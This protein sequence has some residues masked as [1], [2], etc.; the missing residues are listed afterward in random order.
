[1]PKVKP[2]LPSPETMN[3]GS[4]GQRWLSYYSDAKNKEF[5]M[6]F[7]LAKEKLKSVREKREFLRRQ[8]DALRDRINRIQ[9]LKADAAL[10][11][12]NLV[13]KRKQFQTR[14]QNDL[15]AQRAGMEERRARSI[16]DQQEAR[17]RA[18]YRAQASAMRSAGKGRIPEDI[19]SGL[20][21]AY[22]NSQGQII[23]SVELEVTEDG[24]ISTN[25]GEAIV[26]DNEERNSRTQSRPVGE[27]NTV[28]DAR[29]VEGAVENITNKLLTLSPGTSPEDAR[30]LAKSQVR[31]ELS[32]LGGLGEKYLQNY[33][34]IKE[35][36]RP[37]APGGVPE[38]I[39][40]GLGYGLPQD[41]RG[42]DPGPLESPDLSFLNR[43]EASLRDALKEAERR[44]QTYEEPDLLDLARQQQWEKFD[45]MEGGAEYPFQAPVKELDTSS[46]F[47][48]RI[49]PDV[50]P[51][52]IPSPAA[53]QRQTQESP[54]QQGIVQKSEALPLPPPED[55]G[56]LSVDEK[57]F[58]DLAKE[59]L[60]VPQMPQPQETDWLGRTSDLGSSGQI[61][62][63]PQFKPQRDAPV[64]PQTLEGTYG[65]PGEI[66]KLPSPTQSVGRAG[67]VETVPGVYPQLPQADVAGQIDEDFFRQRLLPLQGD[68]DLQLN[69]PE[70]PESRLGREMEPDV[71]EEDPFEKEKEERG[72]G[73]S[74]P[75][76][77]SV[78]NLDEESLDVIV[79]DYY[80]DGKEPESKKAI[81]VA[82][83]LWESWVDS[84]ITDPDDV[85]RKASEQIKKSE[86]YTN[87]LS[88]EEK[89]D[90]LLWLIRK[91]DEEE[92]TR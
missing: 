86:A 64:V 27:M 54:L 61:V 69:L 31:K 3:P 26:R 7:E 5:K 29:M 85:A 40:G 41:I 84:G 82:Q 70:A 62:N 14:E 49:T 21:E 59:R 38:P 12:A 53:V 25:L 91:A 57:T 56:G 30:A 77:A 45:R 37:A 36:T 87:Y 9:Q 1:M 67:V 32:D 28:A 20:E 33:E 78:L 55:L 11:Q 34:S 72:L 88:K 6:S 43:E 89:A 19:Y 44:L 2:Q 80:F 46:L 51:Q 15:I 4:R 81:S 65:M 68:V 58:F 66:T 17:R 90:A 79:M 18:E 8:A 35:V 50:T 23:N 48:D 10:Q 24:D 39:Q 76:E 16:A 13:E 71:P 52:D 22:L 63:L 74:R 47:I 73:E 92:G 75:D 60:A 83:T 42:Y